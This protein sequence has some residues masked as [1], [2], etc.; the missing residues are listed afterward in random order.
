MQ[1]QVKTFL[2]AKICGLFEV[3]T[4]WPFQ[5]KYRLGA[6]GL[7]IKRDSTMWRTF[8]IYYSKVGC[9]GVASGS[10]TS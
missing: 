2:D 5:N 7:S 1:P 3:I 6:R 9:L 10:P 8:S 4:T